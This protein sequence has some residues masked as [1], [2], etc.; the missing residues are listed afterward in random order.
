MPSDAPLTLDEDEEEGLDIEAKKLNQKSRD[1]ISNDNFAVPSKRKLPIHDASHVRNALARINQTKGLTPAEKSSALA[2]IHRAAKKFGIDVQAEGHES[3]TNLRMQ[4]VIDAVGLDLPEVKDHPNRMPFSGVL[5]KIGVASDK[6]PNGTDGKRVLLTKEAVEAALSSLLGMGIDLAK[7][8]DAH[9]VKTKVGIITDAAIDGEDLRIKGFIYA[10]D[11]PQEAL[12]IHLKQAQLGFS[13]E[14]QQVAVESADTDPLVVKSCV[15]TGAAI[16]MKDAAAYQTTSLAAAA[17]KEHEM[18]E[19]KK[20]LDDALKAALAPVTEQITK[21]S[22]SQTSLTTTVDELKKNPY[23]VMA[24]SVMC[25]KMEPHAN[26]LEAAADAMEKDG[27]GL[28]PHSGHVMVARRMAASIRS[29]AA[30]GKVPHTFDESK[31]YWAQASTLNPIWQQPT[32]IN[33]QQ[34]AAKD[35]P[36]YKALETQLA[37]IQASHKEALDK[38]TKENVDALASMNTKM[39]DLTAKVQANAS[40]PDRKTIPAGIQSLLTKNG[41]GEGD[42]EGGRIPVAKIDAALANVDLSQRLA[43][44]ASLVR[45]GVLQN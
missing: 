17:A 21:L 26:H 14:A 7:G 6:A 16:L 22:A 36:E 34:P 42:I 8:L 20:L 13:F 27:V 30:N 33:T 10:A 41:I 31:S 18:E 12:K 44:K 39:A 28:A 3:L 40:A 11:F 15:F 4:L 37:A 2:R 45:A 24:N 43:V 1:A 23:P 25:A 38:T 5:T 35:S 9:D 29:D 19:I 32:V